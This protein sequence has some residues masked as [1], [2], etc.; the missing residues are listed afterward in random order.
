[1][2]KRRAKTALDQGMTAFEASIAW[3]ET[4]AQ[5]A[6]AGGAMSAMVASAM[7]IAWIN[8]YVAG[9]FNAGDGGGDGK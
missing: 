5:F 6:G 4:L 1:M 2:G 9:R 7:R 8:G 3:K